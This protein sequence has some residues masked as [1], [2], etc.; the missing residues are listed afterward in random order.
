M[1]SFCQK[2]LFLGDKHTV[3]RGKWLRNV[4]RRLRRGN[5]LMCLMYLFPVGCTRRKLSE[6][7]ELHQGHQ[8]RMG[9]YWGIMRHLGRGV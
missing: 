2:E 1:L 3:G 6:Q 8:T 9:G 5:Q 4:A 7:D